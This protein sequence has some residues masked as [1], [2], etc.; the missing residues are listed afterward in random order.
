MELAKLSG[1]G[2]AT[3]ARYEAGEDRRPHPE[4]VRKLAKALKVRPEELI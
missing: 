2:R 4:T 3:I 1:V